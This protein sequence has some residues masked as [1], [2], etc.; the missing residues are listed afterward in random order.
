MNQSVDSFIN[1][2]IRH[3]FSWLSQALTTPM[4]APPLPWQEPE[5]YQDITV[6][7]LP[8]KGW[9]FHG[10]SQSMIWQEKVCRFPRSSSPIREN[11]SYNT[12][13]FTSAK[14]CVEAQGIPGGLGGPCGV[15][16]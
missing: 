10:H 11:S 5:N 9:G 12:K 13:D 4:E 1:H 16:R 6:Q 7:L 14:T 3:T 8:R 15:S 2:M